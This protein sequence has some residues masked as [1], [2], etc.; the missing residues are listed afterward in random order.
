[1][2]IRKPYAF[3]IKNFRKIHVF[4][5]LLSLF[6][7]YKLFDVSSFV[8]EFMRLGTYDL[9]KDPITKHITGW[10]MFSIFLLIVGS[11]SLLFLLL[12]KKKPWKLYLVPV[13]EYFVLFLVLMMIRSFFNGFSNDVETTDL[14]LSR[15][16]LMIF[17]IAQLP[18]I[19]VYIMRVFGL[20]FKKF[21]FNSDKEFL[22]LSEEDREEIEIGISFD[23]NTLLRVFRKHKRHAMYFYEE[24]KRIC[25]GIVAILGIVLLFNL[26]QLIFVTHKSYSEG[27]SYQINGFTFKINKAYYTDKDFAGNVIEK[28]SSFVIIDLTIENHA[29]LRTVYLENFHIRNGSFD[30]ITTNKT[31]A[32]EFQDLGMSYESARNLK[33]GEVLNCIIIYKVNKDLKKDRFVLYYQEN[34]G[35]LRKIKLNVKDVSKIGEIEKLTMGDELDLGFQYKSDVIRFEYALV[36]PDV[37]Y[38]TQEC[39]SRSCSFSEHYLA[40]G[41]DF[42]F[43]EIVFSSDVYEAKNM[44]DFLVNY[45]KLNYKD[46]NDKED[47]IELVNA[48]PKSYYG[49]SVFFK[50]PVELETAKE[51][52]LDFIVRNKHYQY[53]IA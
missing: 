31:Y 49:K 34:G 33:N 48:I 8:N 50:V 47:T 14:R 5:L 39:N 45:G 24:H 25:Q 6:V 1:M 29:G 2:I 35:Y 3:L 32:K 13:V 52:Y 28:N 23:K 15:D 30:S 7:A 9:Y 46:A 18:V 41:E 42:R 36:N 4:L 26:Y 10:L 51:L 38:T 37:T 27:D 12:H 21:D 16:L 19:A 17:I 43:L 20:D 44:V 22:E 11:V 53:Q 40:A